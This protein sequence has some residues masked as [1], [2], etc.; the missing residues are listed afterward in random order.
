MS[1][2]H[3]HSIA[4]SAV[5]RELDEIPDLDCCLDTLR[6]LVNPVDDYSALCSALLRHGYD[7]MAIDSILEIV[8]DAGDGLRSVYGLHPE[9]RLLLS[10]VCDPV[11][12]FVLDCLATDPRPLTR[13]SVACNPS[14]P[15]GVLYRLSGD[16]ITP[17]ALAV[18]QNDRSSLDVLS[19]LIDHPVVEVRTTAIEQTVR[20]L[21]LLGGIETQARREADIELPRGRTYSNGV[22]VTTGD[23]LP[24][25]TRPL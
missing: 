13:M 22:L 16:P 23:T 9:L 10:A 18:A 15:E 8:I 12:E 25:T 2:S 19:M 6:R 20:T 14:T 5:H 17:I 21:M 24:G 7:E 3:D 4:L 11:N 1:T